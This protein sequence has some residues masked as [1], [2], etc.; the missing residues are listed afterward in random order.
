MERKK[1]DLVIIDYLQLMSGTSHGKNNREREVAEITR[2][3]KI[4]AK[5]LECPVIALSQ[6]NRD[7]E[8]RIDKR[9]KPS[10]LRESGALEQDSD[11]ILFLY[12]DEVYEKNTKDIGIAEII[13][14][15]NR[16]GETGT[17]NAKFEGEFL[18]FTNIQERI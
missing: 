11:L 6:L 15:K 16:R 7:L 9:P 18:S 4:L 1:V 3:L 8:S 5:E 12:R 10:D 17:V 2:G 14:A 13:V